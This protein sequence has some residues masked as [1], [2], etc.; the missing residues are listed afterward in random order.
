MERKPTYIRAWRLAG[1]AQKKPGGYTLEEMVGRLAELGVETTG[2]SLSRIETGKQPYKQDI[3][4]AIAEALGVT[5]YDLLRNNPAIP[6]A[7][8]YSLV[9]HLDAKERQQATAVLKAMFGK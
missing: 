5:A 3:L 4:E 7:E 6:D 9:D 2:A 1:G 8:I